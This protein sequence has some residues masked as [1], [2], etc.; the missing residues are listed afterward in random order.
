MGPHGTWFDFIP[1]IEGWKAQAQEKLGREWT[2]QVFQA[3]YFE[4]THVLVAALVVL[5]LTLARPVALGLSLALVAASGL[6]SGPRSAVAALVGAVI[7]MAN[8]WVIGRL[9]AR[10][11]RQALIDHPHSAASGLQA[12]LGAKTIVLLLTVAILGGMAGLDGMGLPMLPLG[13]GL[14]VTSFALILA[15]LTSAAA[16]RWQPERRE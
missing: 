2:W 13:L 1:G 7:S 6:V 15:G 11:M 5:L 16:S 8:V 4:I 9:A 3:T 14:L 12:A 10:A